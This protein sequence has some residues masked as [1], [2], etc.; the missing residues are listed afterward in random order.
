[1]ESILASAH[2]FMDTTGK[3][4]IGK[5][6]LEMGIDVKTATTAMAEGMTDSLRATAQS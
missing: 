5:W 3:I 6:A 4:D 1:M 2:A